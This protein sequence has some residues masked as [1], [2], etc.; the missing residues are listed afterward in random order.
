MISI[1]VPVYNTGKYL[2][3]CIDSILAQTYRDFELI[4]VDDGSKDDSGQICDAYA[5]KD[6]R[7]QVIHKSNGGSSSARNLGILKSSG[8]YIGFI[9]SDD[10]IDPDMYEKLMS[11][12]KKTGVKCAQIG[13]DE[14]D[15]QGNI[16]PDICVPPV[17]LE[18]IN[19]RDFLKELLMHRGDCSFCTKL[20]KRD[21]F[22][23]GCEAEDLKEDTY[24]FFP[25]GVLNE[26]FHILVK[27]LRTIGDIA[28][29]P[30]H[31]YHVFYR[32]GSNS[33]KEDKNDFSRVFGD[34]VDNADM[35]MGIVS[36][37]YP[38]DNELNKIAFRFNVF[39]RL[40]YMLHI[41]VSMMDE[42]AESKTEGDKPT[43]VKPEDPDLSR[44]VYVYDQYRQIVKWL[45]KNWGRSMTNPILTAKNKIYHTL[46]AISPKG[47]RKLHKKLKHMD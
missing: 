34:N 32:L 45:R 12:V 4:L 24:E 43:D 19:S 2:P 26:D 7:I 10:S 20:I 30:G 44:Q 35:I 5:E 29:L 11:A 18:I 46:F 14:I 28:S 37:N 25:I 31:K 21:I 22:F 15:E 8:E 39:Q 38:E 23:D 36:E 16:M 27:K 6:P 40:D 1:I 9:D 41:P 47:I 3:K 42:P 13:R 17:E 33:R